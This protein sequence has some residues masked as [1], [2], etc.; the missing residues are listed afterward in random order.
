VACTVDSCDEV[1]DGCAHALNHSACD[2]GNVCTR[3]E[4]TPTGC[5]NIDDQCDDIPTT[6]HW[7]LAMLALCLLI[8]AKLR[9]QINREDARVGR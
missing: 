6:S 1:A 5:L 4:C 3:D 9:F 7:G 8:G 2:D